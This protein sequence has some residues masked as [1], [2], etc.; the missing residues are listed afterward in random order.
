MATALPAA[1]QPEPPR[2]GSFDV[3]G[4]FT[5]VTGDAA[6]FQ[7]YRDLRDG[8]FLENF[9]YRREAD[10]WLFTA[11]FDKVGYRD[12]RYTAGYNRFGR[13][14]AWFEW[15]QVPLFYSIDTRTPYAQTSAGV[16]VIDDALQQANS[17][18]GV[19]AT[20]SP[21][22]L[23]QRRDTARFG[24]VVS[25]LANLDLSFTVNSARRGGEMQWAGSF[26]FSN[27]VEV[28]VPLDQRTT[29]LNAAAEWGNGR[30]SLR[31][32]YDGSWFNNDVQTLVWDNPLRAVDSPTAGSSRGRM[33][34]WPNSTMN[35][36]SVTGAIAL[37]A[38]SRAT[39]YLSVGAWD[40]DQDLLPFTINS[41]IGSIP[42][43]R[44]TADAHAQVTAANL[45]FTSRPVN[46]LWLNVRY[47]RYDFDN[48][49]PEFHVTSSVAYD[50]TLQ[51]SLLTAAEPFG[52]VR[53]WLEADA[54]YDVTSFA[55]LR[56]GYGLE[57]VDRSFRLFE[58]TTEHTFRA[59]I[60]STGSHRLSV[61][62]VYEHGVRTGTG[63]D[64][65][66]LDDIGEQ[67]SLRQFDISDRNRHRF[68][69]IVQVLP[70]DRV[71][72]SGTIGVGRDERP[73][74]QFGLQHAN[75]RFYSVG[76][77]VTPIDTVTAGLTWGFDKYTTLQRSRQ[78][79]PGPQFDDPTRDW[80]TDALDR[81]HYVTASVDVLRA[82]PNSDLRFAYDFNRA[83]GRYTYLVPPDSTLP[84]P[85]QLPEILNRFN[86]FRADF[87]YYFARRVAA[88]VSYLYDDYQVN[89]FALGPET[90]SRINMPGALLLGSVW[91]P[92]RANTGWVRLS[93][94]W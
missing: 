13:V 50:Q 44:P 1:A 34:L 33:A 30:G 38:R 32:Q 16:F 40:Q 65:E 10:D 31:V 49:T 78:A 83:I 88:G 63:L 24:A 56:L 84:P 61:R 29:D 75:T 11:D 87:Q 82:I 91:R 81:I 74:A 6:R 76:V 7:R 12:Q 2:I 57:D 14:K 25:P 22:E 52:Y 62:G 69:T 92:Y 55:A 3:G 45:A 21:F 23:R 42:L 80:E 18:P 90:I 73:D 9:R 66:A 59:S 58:T 72:L 47:R 64:E 71:G 94:F 85:Q 67:V 28:P 53:N 51:T 60:D 35:A 19:A 48:Q 41:A 54:S 4:R 43:D 5:D 46:R 37:P 89:D 36:V 70:L 79:N 68:S 93:Y 8:L 39:A 20:A 17:L 86:Q 77:D 26:G 27:T 15:D